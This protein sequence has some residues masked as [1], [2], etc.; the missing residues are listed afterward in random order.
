MNIFNPLTLLI[1]PILGSLFIISFPLPASNQGDRV[2]TVNNNVASTN[3]LEILKSL[4]E[5]TQRPYSR[6]IE[7]LNKAK[8]EKKNS[9]LKKIAIITSLINFII[10]IL[11]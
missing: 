3:K 9:N 2:T 7:L 11:L 8:T 1:I 4:K 5:N 10:S 6:V